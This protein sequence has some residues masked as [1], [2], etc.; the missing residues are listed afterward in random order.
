MLDSVTHP[1]GVA[2]LIGL[3]V[4]SRVLHRRGTQTWKGRVL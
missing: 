3:V 1:V 4:R 2:A